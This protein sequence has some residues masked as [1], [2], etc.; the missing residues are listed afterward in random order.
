MSMKLVCNRDGYV[1]LGKIAGYQGIERY[2]YDFINY[3]S[4]LIH[5]HLTFVCNLFSQKIS[6]LAAKV[7]S[8][9]QPSRNF[10]TR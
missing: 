2:L 10:P 7:P 8:E 1:K 5:P 9:S 4:S 3:D 6:T